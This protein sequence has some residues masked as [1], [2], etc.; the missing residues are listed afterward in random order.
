LNSEE[1]GKQSSHDV[2][3][4]SPDQFNLHFSSIA[5]AV[6]LQVFFD[7]QKIFEGFAF[8]EDEV[9]AII[10]SIGSGP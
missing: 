5:A 1:L 7:K 3:S 2:F 10:M 8:R 6:C 4:F 9:F